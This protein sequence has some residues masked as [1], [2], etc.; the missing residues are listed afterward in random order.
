M[1]TLN[2][3]YVWDVDEPFAGTIDGIIQLFEIYR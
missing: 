3:V 2:N 1:R